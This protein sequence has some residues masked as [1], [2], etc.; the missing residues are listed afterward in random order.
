[1][2]VI[3]DLLSRN[4]NQVIE[5]IIQVDQIDE[6]TVYSEITEYVATNRIKEHYKDLLEAIAGAPSEPSEGIGIWISGF[7]GSGKSS[8]AKNLGYVLSNPQVLGHSY[9]ELF[10]DQLDHKRISDLAQFIN[11]RIPTE[12]VM[13]DISKAKEVR[14][15]DEKIAEVIYRR[16]LSHLGYAE[17]YDIAEL[18]IELEGD[19]RLK[20]FIELSKKVNGKDWNA[21][22]KGA[23]KINYASAILCRMKPE[24]FPQADSWGQGTTGEASCPQR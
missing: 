23:M 5:E 18:E 11:T 14:R 7:F 20:E 19:G 1:M 17:D 6:Q 9:S 24:L 15:G 21:A 4:L 10:K 13:F 16:L 8:F 3:G 22:R 12:M 2:E